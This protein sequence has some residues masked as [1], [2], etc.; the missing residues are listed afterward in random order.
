MAA[1][2][3]LNR[4]VLQQH[5]SPTISA[6][7]RSRTG[8]R[9][10]PH[11]R[12]PHGHHARGTM[13]ARRRTVSRYRRCGSRCTADRGPVL[14]TSSIAEASGHTQVAGD[15]FTRRLS[16]VPLGLAGGDNPQPEVFIDVLVPAYRSRAH[17]NVAIAEHLFTTEVP[18]LSMALART[19]ATLAL[20]MHRLNG[21]V[22]QSRVVVSRRGERCGTEESRDTGPGQGH[23]RGRHRR[24]LEVVLAA[25]LEPPDFARGIRAESAAV[26]QA[27]SPAATDQE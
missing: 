1:D 7:S 27:R 4:L 15:R 22:R 13:A 17:Q 23:R 25:G 3:P 16:D 10:L 9:R 8:H 21:E 11:N 24:C 19:P 26:I 12:R 20:E 2:T 6:T 18:E 14:Q 5:Q